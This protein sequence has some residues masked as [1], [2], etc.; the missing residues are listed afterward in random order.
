MS[1]VRILLRHHS[2]G[3][4]SRDHSALS[5]ILLPPAGMAGTGKG[6]MEFLDMKKEVVLSPS[7]QSCLSLSH[8]IGCSRVMWEKFSQGHVWE[9]NPQVSL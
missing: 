6:L 3:V 7:R 4:R 5:G 1:Q 2:L 9:I 8:P